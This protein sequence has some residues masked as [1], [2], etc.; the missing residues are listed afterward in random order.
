MRD[1]GIIDCYRYKQVSPILLNHFRP[2]FTLWYDKLECSIETNAFRFVKFSG[3]KPESRSQSYKIIWAEFT[4]TL[5]KLDH[6]ILLIKIVH[7]Y[8][9][10]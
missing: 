3:V 6:L 2:L 7:Q 4:Y 8:A 10:V 1:V 5:C 9:M